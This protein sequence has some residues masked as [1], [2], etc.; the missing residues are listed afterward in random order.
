VREKEVMARHPAHV[1]PVTSPTRAIDGPLPKPPP[2]AAV[3][4]PAGEPEHRNRSQPD[5]LK[6]SWD[7][8]S[9]DM[10]FLIVELRRWVASGMAGSRKQFLLNLREAVSTYLE[11]GNLLSSV[12]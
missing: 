10:T 3:S 6:L 4:V 12:V 2:A 11:P 8:D 1:K 7:I 5:A 9:G